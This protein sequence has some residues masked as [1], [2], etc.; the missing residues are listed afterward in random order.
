MFPSHT[1]TPASAERSCQHRAQAGIHLEYDAIEF[2][3]LNKV[4]GSLHSEQVLRKVQN[5]V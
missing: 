2:L 3:L 1:K 5:T 4:R